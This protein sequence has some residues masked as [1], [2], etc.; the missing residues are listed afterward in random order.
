MEYIHSGGI[1]EIGFISLRTQVSENSRKQFQGIMWPLM[2]RDLFHF[3]R[4]AEKE[5]LNV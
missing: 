4:E 1:P 3:S 5:E 2:C